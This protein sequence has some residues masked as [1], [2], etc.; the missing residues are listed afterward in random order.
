MRKSA[1][2]AS[3]LSLSSPLA[4]ADAAP[5]Y[6]RVEFSTE[7]ARTIDND[8]L[9]ASLS[10]E[11]SDKDAGKLAQ[12]VARQLNA[13][14]KKAGRYPSV[15]TS[16]GNQNTWPLYSTHK[17]A[18]SKLEG[19]RTRAEIRLEST[20]FKAA[21]ELIAALQ[22]TMQLSGIRFSVAPDTRKALEDSLTREAIAAFRQRADTIRSAWSAK[23]YRL[24]QMNIGNSS[25]DYSPRMPVMMS[26]KVADAEAVPAQDMAG[27]DSRI[28]INVNGSIE[29][30]P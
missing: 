18:P 20:D 8:L 14:M 19:W 10:I 3:L 7:V 16:S 23:S 25:P 15:K 26:M 30:Q 17:G 22:E 13:A 4:L 27:G 11:L 6:Q 21:A 24:V 29:L 5:V 2:F 28:V 9:Q 1:L 12:E